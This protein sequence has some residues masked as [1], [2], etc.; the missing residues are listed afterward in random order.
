[1]RFNTKYSNESIKKNDLYT[2]LK[3]QLTKKKK[4]KKKKKRYALVKLVSSISL[5]IKTT[6]PVILLKVGFS[7]LL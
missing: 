4:K 2:M 1:M 7:C 3:L 6:F 5:D